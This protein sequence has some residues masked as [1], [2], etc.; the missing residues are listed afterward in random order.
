MLGI[1]FNFSGTSG[2]AFSD[3]TMSESAE[4]HRGGIVERLAGNDFFGLSDVRNYFFV[5]RSRSRAAAAGGERDRCGHHF[6]KIAAVDG[7]KPKGRMAGRFFL[8]KLL[9]LGTV[10]ELFEGAPVFATCETAQSL[11]QFFRTEFFYFTLHCILAKH[12]TVGA[13]ECWTIDLRSRIF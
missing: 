6:Q 1:A 11:P 13:L 10:R 3:H 9:K 12:G 7:V 4:R 8:Q 2:V 5:R